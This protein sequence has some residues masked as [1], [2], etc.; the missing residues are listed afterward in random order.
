MEG[1]DTKE[2]LMLIISQMIKDIPN[3]QELGKIMREN[4]KDY[5]ED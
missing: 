4:F 5:F 1:I 3:D 2:G